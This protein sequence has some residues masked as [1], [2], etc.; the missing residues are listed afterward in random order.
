MIPETF[1][2]PGQ[3]TFGPWGAHTSSLDW[4][5]D[6]YT[7]SRYIAEF[8]NTTSN[9]PFILLG[10]F[11]ILSTRGLPNRTRYALAHALIAIIGT[12]SFIFHG[13]L[14]WHAQVMMDELPMLWCS[15]ML[16]YLSGVGAEDRPSL[17]SKVLMA[18]V[19]TGVSWI[20]LQYPDPILHQVAFATMQIVFFFQV[21]RLFSKVPRGTPTQLM[22]LQEAKMHFYKGCIIFVGGFAIWNVDNLMCGQLTR[23]RTEF[24]GSELVGMLTQG[25][26]WWHLMTGL[27][28]SR[29]I[30]ATTYLVLAVRRP[31]DFE[32]ASFLGHPFVRPKTPGEEPRL[33]KGEIKDVMV[34]EKL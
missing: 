25:H 11:G 6:N 24:G 4:C 7:H 5:E 22:L 16:L 32:M 9:I 21:H 17:V 3:K 31:D 33:E 2:R 34:V 20:Y 12:G 1:H 19:P 8:W 15:S 18:M 27:G 28:A 14:L 29:I 10:I 13:T 23:V 30:S 26:A